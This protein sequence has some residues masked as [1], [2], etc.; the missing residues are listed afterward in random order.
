MKLRTRR[1]EVDEEL[2]KE[3][4]KERNE[5]QEDSKRAAKKKADEEK[6]SKLS[7]AE[8]KKVSIV[9]C[10]ICCL[11]E[12]NFPQFE[13]KERKRA[14]RKQQGKMVSRK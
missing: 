13:E 5:E 10:E 2:R 7:A 4:M 11:T 1:E 9:Q 12:M 6:I 14:I 3:A 8:Q